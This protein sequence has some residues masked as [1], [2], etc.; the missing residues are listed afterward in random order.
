VE[1][2]ANL[3]NVSLRMKHYRITPCVSTVRAKPFS[4]EPGDSQPRDR[5]SSDPLLRGVRAHFA[6]QDASNARQSI[7]FAATWVASAR[8]VPQSL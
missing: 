6:S 8:E 7:R 2:F 3:A 1:G 4:K 5:S